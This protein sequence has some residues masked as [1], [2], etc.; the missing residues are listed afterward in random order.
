MPESL[1]EELQKPYGKV[2]RGRGADLVKKI[3]ELRKARYVA[4]IGDLVSLYTLQAG[5]KPDIVV[6]DYKTERESLDEDFSA[7][8]SKLL[9]NYEKVEA[10]N[11]Q[12]CISEDLV[13]K[14]IEAVRNLGR[15]RTAII[16]K[17]EEDL[18]SLVLA[19][20]MPAGS[21]ILYGIPSVGISAYEVGEKVLILNLLQKF[22]AEK[23]D[24]VMK[25]IE[26]VLK[27]S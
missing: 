14:L 24:R 25:M 4:C 13:G 1:R 11:P 17:G 9:E 19:A 12:S 8:M 15:K 22:E 5:Y 27:W 3:E 16:I 18:A 20:I 2:Y 26:E 21:L 6:L 23:N 10:E 7:M